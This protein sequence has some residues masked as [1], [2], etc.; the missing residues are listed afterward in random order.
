MNDPSTAAFH[1]FRSARAATA[2][3]VITNAS[4]VPMHGS[5]IPAPFASPVTRHRLPPASKTAV[6][7]FG[8]VS[9]VMMPRAAA[10]PPSARSPFANA[11]MP[12]RIFPMSSR[13]PMRPVEHTSI[14]SAPTPTCLAAQ[15]AMSVASRIPALPVHAFA[16]PLFTTTPRVRPNFSTRARSSRTVAACTW[17]V[18]N[19]AAT[20]AGRS[21]SNIAMSAVPLAFSPAA[22]P[23]ARHPFGNT[24]F[25]SIFTISS[26]PSIKLSPRIL[27]PSAPPRDVFRLCLSVPLCEKKAPRRRGASA[28]PLSDPTAPPP[29]AA[30]C[31]PD[32]P[33]SPRRPC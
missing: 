26:V 29:P 9:V 5:I 13:T 14:S 22:V 32:T 30:P 7:R 8:R 18:V 21:L 11:S 31:L 28:I 4:I 15:A 6:N 23:A 24:A 2:A 20:V 1:S 3:S 12:G 19:V 16:W 33:G 25:A 17:F 10:S 27:R